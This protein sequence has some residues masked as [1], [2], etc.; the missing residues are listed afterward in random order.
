MDEHSKVRV[1]SAFPVYPDEPVELEV[2]GPGP[3]QV[4]VGGVPVPLAEDLQADDLWH[5]SVWFS[6]SGWHEV[7][8]KDAA[9]ALFVARPGAWPSLR[10]EVQRRENALR[11]GDAVSMLS[12]TRSEE[13]PPLVFFLIFLFAAAFVWLSPKL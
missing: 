4:T 11:A 3:P 2:V 8:G 7:K 1:A 6:G 12:A 5:G 9:A 10:A 13:V